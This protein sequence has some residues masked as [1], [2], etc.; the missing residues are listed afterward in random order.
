MTEQEENAE[1]LASQTFW[2]RRPHPGPPSFQLP[3]E[4]VV[5]VHGALWYTTAWF[6]PLTRGACHLQLNKPF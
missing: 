5:T 6:K 1:P 3:D 2:S 4:Q